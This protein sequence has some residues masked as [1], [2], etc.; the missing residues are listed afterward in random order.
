MLRGGALAAVA[1]LL[2]AGCGPVG[3]TRVTVNRPLKPGDVAFI[4]PRK[5]TFTEVTRRLGVP[6]DI[7]RGLRR[8]IIAEY[9]SSDSRSFSV[10]FGWPLNFIGPV[11]EVPHSFV[12]GGRGIG[13][14]TFEVS[15]DR[16]DVVVYA[17][18]L[19]GAPASQYRV[20][21]FGSPSVSHAP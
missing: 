6:D 4:V 17:G 21:P 10:N 1:V 9:V 16:D 7:E 2:L 15:F 11:S 14:H 18:F 12:L 5:T 3:W 13:T 20:W 8:G 19:P